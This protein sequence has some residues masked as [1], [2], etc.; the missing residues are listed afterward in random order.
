MKTLEQRL[1][2][3]YRS[4]RGLMLSGDDVDSL[5]FD[6]AIGTRISDTAATEA[7][8]GPYGEDSVPIRSGLSPTWREFVHRFKEKDA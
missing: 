5:V 2:E 1:Y 8:V 7:G 6:D 3:A 4:G